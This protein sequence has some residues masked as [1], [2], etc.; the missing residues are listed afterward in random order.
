MDVGA[1]ISRVAGTN[2]A[3]SVRVKSSVGVPPATD[4][5]D[6]TAIDTTVSFAD[7]ESTKRISITLQ[8][9]DIT[10]FSE[11]FKLSLSTPNNVSLG[12][13]ITANAEIKDTDIDFTSTLTLLA[14]DV[15]NLNIEKPQL[16]DLNQAS[17]LDTDKKIL[18]LVNTIPILLLTDVTAK[19]DASG[20]LTIDIETD[21]LYFRPMAVKK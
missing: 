17:L 7:R 19:Q 21:R 4:I 2:G 13:I 1:T 8:K 16:L 18:D 12:T 10:E 9:D 3:A 6:D 20:L 14:K 15:T 5:L 11:W